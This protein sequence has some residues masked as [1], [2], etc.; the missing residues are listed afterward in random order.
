MKIAI[1]G[2]HAGYE[3]KNSLKKYLEDKG[4]EVEDFGPKTDES[5]DYPDIAHPLAKSVEEG[6]NRLGIAICGS[7]NGINMTLNKHQEIRSALCWNPDL[8]SLAR[9][10]NNANVMALPSRF[11]DLDLAKECVD[12]FIGQNFEGGRHERRVNKIKL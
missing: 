3:Y 2:D 5:C 10:H 7:G 8:A 1:G 12:A 9:Q 11:I 6:I 4:H